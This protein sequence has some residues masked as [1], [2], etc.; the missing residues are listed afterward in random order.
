M[1]QNTPRI[2]PRSF[3]H[4]S[5]YPLWKWVLAGPPFI[6]GWFAF[7]RDDLLPADVASKLRLGGVFAMIEWYWWVIIALAIMFISTAWSASRRDKELL[8]LFEKPKLEIYYDDN[9]PQCRKLEPPEKP[10]RMYIRLKIINSADIPA[11]EC[12]GWL[13]SILQNDGKPHPKWNNQMIG[14]EGDP[15]PKPAYIAKKIGSRFLDVVYTIDGD[16]IFR[17]RTDVSAGKKGYD[18]EYPIGRYYFHIVI[19][20]EDFD[21]SEQWFW[22]NW[23]GNFKELTMEKIDHAPDPPA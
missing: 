16:N 18:W 13:V 6:Y 3:L 2:K 9:D 7:I 10:E 23:N 4:Y 22:V 19:E 12:R 15:I 21:Q 11:K 5:L 20:D 1:A 14:W 17:V 8:A